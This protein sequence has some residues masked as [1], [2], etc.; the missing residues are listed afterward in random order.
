MT[1]ALRNAVAELRRE[2]AEMREQADKREA[3]AKLLEQLLD[4][5]RIPEAPAART[6]RQ[7]RAPRASEPA[8]AEPKP[9]AG[10]RSI[11]LAA[12]KTLMAEGDGPSAIARK[13]GCSLAGA[14]YAMN[15]ARGGKPNY[16]KPKAAEPAPRTPKAAAKG[17]EWSAEDTARLKDLRAGGMT[18]PQV[19]ATLGRPEADCIQHD[20]AMR[21]AA[22]KAREAK[23]N[24]ARA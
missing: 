15:R 6:P 12:V 19:S 23:L 4:E 11:D 1:D 13:L 20:I 22:E 2:A 18:W 14:A 7:P 10:R 16:S 3:A 17:G 24:G 21:R 8:A 5:G 9:A